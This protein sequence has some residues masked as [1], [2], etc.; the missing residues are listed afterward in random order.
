[1]ATQ[2]LREHSGKCLFPRNPVSSLWLSYCV[3]PRHLMRYIL[4]CLSVLGS[5]RRHPVTSGIRPSDSAPK[6]QSLEGLSGHTFYITLQPWPSKDMLVTG[7][8]LYLLWESHF[9]DCASWKQSCCCCQSSAVFCSDVI[10]SQIPWPPLWW[11]THWT[12]GDLRGCGRCKPSLYF[13]I[14]INCHH[15]L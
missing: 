8:F 2:R 11:R 14:T 15:V 5:G 4:Q 3:L 7:Y 12:E 13:F 6:T 10:R 9:K 1:V